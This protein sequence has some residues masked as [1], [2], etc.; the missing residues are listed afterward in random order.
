MESSDYRRKL[1]FS[2]CVVAI[3]TNRWISSP[4]PNEQNAYAQ[5]F[6]KAHKRGF[7]EC[8][9]QAGC[10]LERPTAQVKTFINFLPAILHFE[11]HH[12]TYLPLPLVLLE[13][14][15]HTEK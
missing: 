13:T 15:V 10:S 6:A 12:L 1:N 9:S 3:Q 11:K 5:A 2:T 7:C 8:G 4:L 14:Y